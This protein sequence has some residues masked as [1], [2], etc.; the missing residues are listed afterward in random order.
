MP[1]RRSKTSSNSNAKIAGAAICLVLIVSAVIL[2]PRYLPQF[3]L[4]GYGVPGVTVQTFTESAPVQQ[5]SYIRSTYGS[6]TTLSYTSPVIQQKWSNLFGQERYVNLQ[7]QVTLKLT[8]Q[9]SDLASPTYE[10][11]ITSPTFCSA[12]SDTSATFTNSTIKTYGYGFKLET[13]WSGTANMKVLSS[14]IDSFVPP[15]TPSYDDLVK[16]AAQVAIQDFNSQCLTSASVLMSINAGALAGNSA[17]SLNPDY[18]GIMGM[19]LINYQTEGVTG[20][21]DAYAL[22]NTAGTSVQLFSDAGLSRACWAPQTDTNGQPLLTPTQTYWL[23]SFAPTS[24]YWGINIVNLGSQ[25][26]YDSSKQGPNYFEWAYEAQNG[27]GS[28]PPVIDQW[29]RVDLAFHTT[30]T[31]KVPQIPNYNL[32]PSERQKLAITLPE[33]PN[34]PGQGG[35][36]PPINSANWIPLIILLVAV[37]GIGVV[38]IMYASKKKTNVPKPPKPTR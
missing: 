23:Q 30:N 5:V 10:T 21:T 9:A 2:L 15:G 4:N 20:G 38:I 8:I 14:R 35:T 18:L 33:K 13:Q 7:L 11:T 12:S 26:V 3:A 31:W 16:G 37:A 24:A 27:L 22:P 36:T 25:L 1:R 28:T 29:F 19:W 32:P 34:N 17:Y 6:V